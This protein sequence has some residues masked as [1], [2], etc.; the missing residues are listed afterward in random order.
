MADLAGHSDTQEK[1][2]A[3][4]RR[5]AVIG[6]HG[7][8]RHEPGA[9]ANAMS[10]LLLSLPS[11]NPKTAE[12]KEGRA[13]CAQNASREFEP[14]ESVGIQIPL[15]PVCVEKAW[16][17]PTYNKFFKWFQE[18]STR[19]ARGISGKNL[20]QIRGETGRRWSV[21]L[22]Q[23]YYGGADSNAYISTRLSGRKISDRTEVL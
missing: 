16:E 11:F 1:G 23:D 4:P 5:V 22:L 18:G 3:H 10:D 20:G 21:K 6:V 17:K 12:P 13:V 19:F 9:T 2:S 7:V 8:A 15:Q 14:F